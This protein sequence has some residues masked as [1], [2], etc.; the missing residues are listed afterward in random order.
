VSVT[1]G[2]SQ[3]LVLGL[4]L[5]SIFINDLDEGIE[6]TL[7]KFADGTKLGGVADTPEGCAAIQDLDRLESRLGREEPDEVQQELPRKAVES[8]FLEI[9][10]TC[11]DNYLGDLL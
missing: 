11:L 4:V 7:S 1:S 6:S 9:F 5:F 10:K 8:P 2:V 3:R